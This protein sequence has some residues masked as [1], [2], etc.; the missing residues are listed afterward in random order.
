MKVVSQ[1]GITVEGFDLCVD[2]NPSFFS[3]KWW[4]KNKPLFRNRIVLIGKF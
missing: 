2:E 4:L 3:V 1:A